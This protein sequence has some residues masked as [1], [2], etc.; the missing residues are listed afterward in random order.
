MRRDPRSVVPAVPSWQHVLLP[1]LPAQPPA[2]V[3]ADT[4]TGV[5]S[6]G[7]HSVAP[8]VPS[9]QHVLLLGLP[10]QPSSGVPADTSA[11]ISH[12]Q[13]HTQPV[14]PGPLIIIS[15]FPRHRET[16]LTWNVRAW[17]FSSQVFGNLACTSSTYALSVFAGTPHIVFKDSL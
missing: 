3:P 6:T 2:A 17:T 1:G 16:A 13:S 4:S 12:Q 8:T 7:P 11:A 9:R 14:S 5:K 15:D 10:A